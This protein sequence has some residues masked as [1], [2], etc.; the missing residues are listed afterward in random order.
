MINKEDLKVGAEFLNSLNDRVKVIAMGKLNLIVENSENYEDIIG[1]AR[2][3]RNWNY[4]PV[5]RK[6]IELKPYLVDSV[7]WYLTDDRKRLYRRYGKLTLRSLIAEC[8][9]KPFPH[10]PSVF[11]WEDTLESVEA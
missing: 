6:K 8:D 1:I 9:L 5:E 11:I 4:V 3:V 10:L 2:A 7:P